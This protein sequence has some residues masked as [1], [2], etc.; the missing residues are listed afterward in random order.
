MRTLT[1]VR[2]E[3]CLGHQVD[4]VPLIAWSGLKNGDLLKRAEQQYEVLLTMD[5]SMRHQ[6]NLAKYK[7]AIIA[8]QAASNR[9]ADT[10][11]LMPKVLIIL[12]TVKPG[13]VVL[14]S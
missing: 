3:I 14:I 9:L 13:T 7:I 2:A 10:R 1:G 12:P 8:L 6:Q 4:S 5:S 11:S